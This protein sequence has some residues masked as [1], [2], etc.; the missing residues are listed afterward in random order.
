[1]YR[2][3]GFTLIELLVV[4]AIIALLMAI[5]M[6]A[7]QRVRNQARAAVCQSNL[8]QWGTLWA[9][10]VDDNQ[11]P[12]RTI[13]CP[14]IGENVPGIGAGVGIGVQAGAGVT[15]ADT[16]IEVGTRKP[17]GYASVRWPQNPH[18]QTVGGG[19]TKRQAERSWHGAGS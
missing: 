14:T 8:K 16:A 10:S 1:M 12:D 3:K 18:I 4:I 9:M 6:P 7:L 5:L 2:A 11:A 17:R 19:S 15:G 13:S